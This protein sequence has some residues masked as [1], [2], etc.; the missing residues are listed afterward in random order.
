V[1]DHDGES[2]A[3]CRAYALS[4][5]GAAY[6]IDDDVAPDADPESMED[7]LVIVDAFA[8]R[9]GDKPTFDLSL[10]VVEDESFLRWQASC[11]PGAPG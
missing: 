11:H 5:N 1:F 2:A 9:S 4:N 3:S 6:H 10:P 7:E 8:I